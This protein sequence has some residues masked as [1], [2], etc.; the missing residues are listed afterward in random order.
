MRSPFETVFDEVFKSP[1]PDELNAD[2]MLTVVAS[3]LDPSSERII[4]YL[5]EFGVPINAVF[6][7]FLE[8]ED[9]QYLAR[10]WLADESVAESS[11]GASRSKTG[12]W[13]GLDWYVNFGEGESRAG[14]DGLRYGFISAGG[15]QWYSSTLRKLPEEARVNVYLPQRGY[16]AVGITLAPARRFD[17]TEVEVDGQKQLLTELEV[18]A[19]YRHTPGSSPEHDEIAEYAVPVRWIRAVPADQ[20]Y[21]EPGMF[22]SQHSACKLRQDFTL[23]KLAEQ[24]PSGT[25]PRF[26]SAICT[27]HGN[28]ASGGASIITICIAR[29]RGTA[30][31]VVRT[32]DATR[33][34][35]VSTQELPPRLGPPP[36]ASP[37]NRAWLFSRQ[38]DRLLV[39]VYLT[40]APSGVAY[41]ASDG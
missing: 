33:V 2:L 26:C 37:S 7:R 1:V 35:C 10:S 9:R 14:D 21:R 30:T 13:N 4:T 18:T 41:G 3:A 32:K 19:T 39:K 22:A 11:S 29:Q 36:Q 27:S 23:R 38:G 8:D 31:V 25:T 24:G 40:R 28:D 20:A 16:V 6:F 34:P 12:P 15:G 5:R 17:E